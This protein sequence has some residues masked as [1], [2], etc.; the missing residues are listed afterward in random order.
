MRIKWFASIFLYRIA[1]KT[2]AEERGIP[3]VAVVAESGV[4][5]EEFGVK[6]VAEEGGERTGRIKDVTEGV[7]F[8]RCGDGAVFVRIAEGVADLVAEVVC[9]A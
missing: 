9:S 8:V 7:V 3:A 2:A 6:A 4:G 1:G 5:I